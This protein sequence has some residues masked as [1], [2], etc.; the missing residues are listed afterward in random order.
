MANRH[1]ATLL[2]ALC[3]SF[4]LRCC[5][6]VDLEYHNTNMEKVLKQQLFEVREY[7]KLVR[8]VRSHN[9]SVTVTIGLSLYHVLA[10]SEKQQTLHALYA[11]R[12]SWFDAHLTWKPENYSGVRTLWVPSDMIWTPDIVLMN[13]YVRF[14]HCRYLL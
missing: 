12:F 14:I 9:D 8:P 3:A 11:L 6:A 7:D 5:D 13:M 10:T 1:A 2:C 4:W